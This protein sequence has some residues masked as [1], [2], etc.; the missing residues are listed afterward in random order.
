MEVVS[1]LWADIKSAFWNE[2]FRLPST[3]TWNDLKRN[4]TVFYPDANDLCYPIAL[5]VGLF[6]LRL[7]W[8]R[9]MIFN[10]K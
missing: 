2:H 7:L 1:E 6:V 9:Y 3:V 10:D 5:A 8:E 4:E